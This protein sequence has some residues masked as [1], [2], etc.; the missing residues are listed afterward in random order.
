MGHGENALG[1]ITLAE[2]SSPSVRLSAVRGRLRVAGVDGFIVPHADE[3]QCEYQPARSARLAWLTGFDGSAGLAVVLVDRAALFVDGRYTLQ[4]RA[5]ASAEDWEFLRLHDDPLEDWLTRVR[6]AGARLA[7]DPRLHTPAWLERLIEALSGRGIDLV[8]IEVDPIDELWTDRPPMPTAPVV[9]HPERFAGVS[10]AEKRAAIGEELRRAGRAAV[11]LAAPE[12]TA[13]LLNLRGGDTRDTP[14]ALARTI[15]DADGSADLFVDPAKLTAEMRA[16]LGPDV[17]VRDEADFAAAL[18]DPARAGSRILVD[19]TLISVWALELLRAS[20]ARVERDADP[21]ALPRARKNGTELAGARAAHLRDARPMV[22]FLAWL[23]EAMETEP[24][25]EIEAADRLEAFRAE[26]DLYRGPSFETIPGSGPNG[27]IV[28]Y[29]A[30]PA[31]DR[32]LE[33]GELFLLDSGAQYLDGTTDVTRTVVLGG[34]PGAEERR[35]YTAVLKG[36]IAL[37]TTRFPPGT[38]G[39]RLDAIARAPLWAEGFDYDH[40]T[41]HGVGSYLSVHEGPQ[42]IAKTSNTIALEP[43]MILSNEPGC[44]LPGRFGV[45]IENLI[46][47]RP[48]ETVPM[49]EFETLTLVPYDRSLIDVSR[50]TGAERAWVDACHALVRESLEPRL[51]ARAAAWLREATAPLSDPA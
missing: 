24:P 48:S 18:A 4:A 11:V 45:R 35:V 22:R 46:V 49:L 16:A 30:T 2:L 36:H 12:S 28:H 32:R 51:D 19:P 7:F 25:T 33:K 8:P 44:Y 29:H 15:L 14:L 23:A 39:P 43:G 31:T 38:S 20:G 26:E 1:V 10:S 3:W 5:Q 17:R 13:W 41:G 42:R 21:C 27:A 6:P 50:L 47:V 37:G 40:G 34:A 9:P